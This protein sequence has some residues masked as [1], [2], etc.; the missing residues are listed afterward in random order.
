MLTKKGRREK[1][2]EEPQDSSVYFI[3]TRLLGY[4]NV[5]IFS[6]DFKDDFG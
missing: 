4:E 5:I 1:R 3:K 2:V 6:I